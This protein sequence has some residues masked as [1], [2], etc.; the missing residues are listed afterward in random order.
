MH[1]EWILNPV[2]LYT[3]VA[4]AL[5]GCLALF[6]SAKVE[7]AAVRR[8]ADAARG[9]LEEMRR[10]AAEKHEEPAPA[11][12][13][14]PQAPMLPALV[15]GLN[16]SKRAQAL[17]MHRRGEPLSSIAAALESPQGEIQLLLKVHNLLNK[18][19]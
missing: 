12:E 5:M 4:L 10:A 17:R 13:V 18:A 16:L 2:T 11:V 8:M 15:S 3:T 6:L 14:A 9:E 7:M 1:L 19:S